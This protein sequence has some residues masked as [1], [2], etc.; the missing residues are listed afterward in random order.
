MW[1]NVI[2]FKRLRALARRVIKEEKRNSWRVFCE[3]LGPETPV[4]QLWSAVHRMSGMYK[5]RSMPVLQ[6]G[7]GSVQYGESR[8][9]G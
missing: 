9:A 8:Y 7:D 4:G 6:K 2:E 1:E 3:K 5:K